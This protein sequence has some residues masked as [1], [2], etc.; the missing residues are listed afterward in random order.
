[1]KQTLIKPALLLALTLVVAIPAIAQPQRGFRGA[2]EGRETMVTEL[3]LSAE[4]EQQ[5]QDLR[6]AREAKAID[7]RADLQQERL[8]LRKLRQADEPNK[9]KLYAQV[10]KIGSVEVKMDK[11]RIDHL[12]AVRGV[13]TE[14]Q[15]KIFNQSLQRQFG[16][17][18]ERGD[19][20][21][22]QSKRFHPDR[23]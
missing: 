6:F 10:E 1:M 12:L 3:K 22:Q 5:M 9:K 23:F 2:G 20:R 18:G 16:Q 8:K 19:K 7:L 4:Q 15:F 11:S 17:R 21:D 14:E 13:L